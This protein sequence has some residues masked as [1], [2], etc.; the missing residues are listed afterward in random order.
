MHDLTKQNL[1]LAFAAATALGA[2]LSTMH[3]LGEATGAA[4]FSVG[5]VF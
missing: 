1:V 4:L 3:T 2:L 5:V